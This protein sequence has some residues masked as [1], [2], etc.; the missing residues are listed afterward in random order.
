[1]TMTNPATSA[2]S[3]SEDDNL[4]ERYRESKFTIFEDAMPKEWMAEMGKWLHSQRCYFNRNNENGKLRYNYGLSDI[5]ELHQ[6]TADL[7]K[8]IV[9]KLDEAI[10]EV[11]IP[12]FDLEHI[13]CHAT[14]YHHGSHFVWHTDHNGYDGEPAL[15][16]RLSYCLYLHSNPKMF[17]GG[18]LEFTDGTMVEPKHNSLVVFEPRQQHRVRRVEC[19]SA[20][21]LHGRWAISGWIHGRIKGSSDEPLEGVPLSG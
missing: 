21:F 13:E 1:M 6:P 20:D 11:G 18:E 15:T 4:P 16:R 8:A 14:L 10:K 7:K 9:A 2:Q 3:A 5:D 12:D 19:W 17:S